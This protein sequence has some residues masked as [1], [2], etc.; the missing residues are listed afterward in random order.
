MVRDIFSAKDL[1]FS[2]V[3]NS[4]AMK[5]IMSN[6]K[7]AKVLDKPSERRQL[8][9]A[10]RKHGGSK[11]GVRKALGDLYHG[12]NDELSRE[13]VSVI[14]KEIGGGSL[15]KDRLIAPSEDK[16]S[17]VRDISTSAKDNSKSEPLSRISIN[18]QKYNNS[19]LIKGTDN[20][21]PNSNLDPDANSSDVEEGA[22]NIWT[23]LA[24]NNK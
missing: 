21:N 11:Q 6:P 9:T 12:S 10:I 4:S 15:G 16:K 8:L 20:S 7:M 5:K 13:E 3:K 23:V 14:G 22:R 24:E 17:S 18:D 2:G 1:K 19:N